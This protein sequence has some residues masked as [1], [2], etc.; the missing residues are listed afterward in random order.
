[1]TVTLPGDVQKFVEEQLAA[2]TYSTVEEVCGL[3]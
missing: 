1:M 3:Q 2:G